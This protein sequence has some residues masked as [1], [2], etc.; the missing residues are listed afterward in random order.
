MLFACVLALG[1]GF[2]LTYPAI[3]LAP[4]LGFMDVPKDERRMHA[5]PTPRMGGAAI[6]LSFMLAL[7]VTGYFFKVLPYLVGGLI[8]VIIGMLDDKFGIKPSLKILGQGL[9]GVVLC[10]FGITLRYVTVFGYTLDLGILAYPVTVILVIGVT[11]I[12][13]LIDGL[14]GLCS[15]ISIF[16]CGGIALCSVIF[17]DGTVAPIA[18]VLLCATLGFL[19]HNTNPAKIF[20]GDTGSMFLGFMLAGLSCATFFSAPEGE[21]TLSAFT[22]FALLGIPI[23]DTAF[24]IVRRLCS[25]QS[26]FCGDKKH[27]HHRLTARY[28]QRLAVALIYLASFVLFGIALILNISLVGEIIGVIL[29]A[30]ALAYA[31][32]R[33]GIIKR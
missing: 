15:G 29:L 25:G 4:K 22:M 16:G 31:I 26:I 30:L 17:G 2:G 11:N 20:L 7:S 21:F 24:A 9:S 8:I 23:F 14:D 18:L 6:F 12:L 32:V 1:L 10:A 13:N 19:P 28:G 33:F 3:K 5:E 27:I